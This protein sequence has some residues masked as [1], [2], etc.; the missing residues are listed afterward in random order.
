MFV[1]FFPRIAHELDESAMI[2][3]CSSFRDSGEYPLAAV[4]PAMISAAIFSFIWTWERLQSQYIYISSV[5]KY[6]VALGLRM[7][8][9]RNGE[10][11]TGLTYWPCRSFPSFRHAN[12]PVFCRITFVEVVRNLR[13]EE[14]RIA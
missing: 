4:R 5:P 14:D 6:T 2:D 10:Y 13:H 1:E 9:D 8:I 11:R 7:A 12:L 3:G